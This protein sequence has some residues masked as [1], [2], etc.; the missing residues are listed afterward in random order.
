ISE[1][2]IL[3]GIMFILIIFLP[4]VISTGIGGFLELDFISYIS[5]AD[6][7]LSSMFYLLGSPEGLGGL[8]GGFLAPDINGWI[9]LL[10]LLTV[11]AIAFL[12]LILRMNKEEIH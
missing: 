9:S 2:S 6:L 1:Q 5:V 11:S 7:S 12:T 8:L 4:S 3:G 10:I